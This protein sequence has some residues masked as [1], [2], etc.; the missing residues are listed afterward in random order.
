MNRKPYDVM[1]RVVTGKWKLPSIALL[2]QLV[3][4]RWSQHKQ[5]LFARLPADAMSL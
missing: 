3:Y 5:K 1:H 4:K 2:G